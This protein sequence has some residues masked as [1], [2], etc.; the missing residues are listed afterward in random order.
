MRGGMTLPF[1]ETYAKRMK[2]QPVNKKFTVLTFS[3]NASRR[4]PHHVIALCLH[5]GRGWPAQAA[6]FVEEPH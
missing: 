4:G 1:M 3:V 2:T 6:F 5:G